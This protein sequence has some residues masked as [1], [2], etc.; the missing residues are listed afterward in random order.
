MNDIIIF[1]FISVCNSC[2]YILMSSI[3]KINDFRL[4]N[5]AELAVFTFAEGGGVT[6]LILMT[7]V[8]DHSIITPKRDDTR[9]AKHP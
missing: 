9:E 2:I 6:E 1:N 4:S 5:R 8:K 7:N 3:I